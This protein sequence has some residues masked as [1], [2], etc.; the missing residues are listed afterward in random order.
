MNGVHR[1]IV[2][3][4]NGP[5]SAKV[6]LGDAERQN[7]RADQEDEAGKGLTSERE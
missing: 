3:L 4:V 7:V 1:R 5:Q 6:P 2:T